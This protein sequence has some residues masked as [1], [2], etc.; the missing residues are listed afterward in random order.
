LQ[1]EKI[2]Q[3]NPSDLQVRDPIKKRHKINRAIRAFKAYIQQQKQT[4]A[5]LDLPPV[6]YGKPPHDQFDRGETVLTSPTTI[7]PTNDTPHLSHVATP[8]DSI[9]EMQTPEFDNRFAVSLGKS[10][11]IPTHTVMPEYGRKRPAPYGH[12]PNIPFPP[13]RQSKYH[14]N[15]SI[16]PE[17][18]SPEANEAFDYDIMTRV[19]HDL[20]ASTNPGQDLNN[21]INDGSSTIAKVENK[22]GVPPGF[23]GFIK[24]LTITR[25]SVVSALSLSGSIGTPWSRRS[26]QIQ[27]DTVQPVQ[28]VGQDPPF[29]HRAFQGLPENAW[30]PVATSSAMEGRVHTDLFQ[31]LLLARHDEQEIANQLQSLI[32]NGANP[33]VRNANG[34][35]PLHVALSL[36]NI[37]ACEALLKGGA[38]VHVKTRDGKSL[39]EYGRAVQKRKGHDVPRYAAIKACRKAIFEHP[40]QKTKKASKRS[41]KITHAPPVHKGDCFSN[42]DHSGPSGMRASQNSGSGQVEPSQAPLMREA[43]ASGCV[44]DAIEV[45]PDHNI[46]FPKY[47]YMYPLGNLGAHR[48]ATSGFMHEQQGNYETP[49][50][51]FP[52]HTI[53]TSRGRRSS[54]VQNLVGF[55][56]GS[57]STNSSSVSQSIQSNNLVGGYDEES[58]YAQP[59]SATQALN[60][61]TPQT[62]NPSHPGLTPIHKHRSVPRTMDGIRH[63]S[64]DSRHGLQAVRNDSEHVPQPLLDPKTPAQLSGYLQEIA[65]GQMALVCPLS[66]DDAWRYIEQAFDSNIY[67][68]AVIQIV[69]VPAIGLLPSMMIPQNI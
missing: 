64:T 4:Q 16:R 19:S 12:D 6:D 54:K 38:D 37:L 10:D 35:T 22:M 63:L 11:Y 21:S 45:A 65:P 30:G 62:I 41:K 33:N 24:R 55:F 51:S 43:N 14:F 36:G 50:V 67:S 7:C 53:D 40:N 47:S 5:D 13:K 29:P 17:E 59:S 66:K 46:S 52:H 57:H 9:A 68:K 27:S 25:D 58:L 8:A 1:W 26:R 60:E 42:R 39:E 69:D 23:L 34:E 49:A 44:E 20:G 15:R 48:S 31:E 61:A 2:A 18:S 32:A 3:M 28:E 56:E